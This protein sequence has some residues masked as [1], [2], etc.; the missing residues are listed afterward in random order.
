VRTKR[1]PRV[2]V[3]GS[4]VSG[5]TAAHELSRQGVDV[6][7]YEREPAP[8]GHVKTVAVEGGPRVDTGFIVY[9][10]RT[11]PRF[12]RLLAELGVET[13][14]SDMS[15]SVSCRACGVEW[16]TRGLRNVFATRRQLLNPRHWGMLRDIF[17]FY[18]DAEAALEAQEP[19]D[20]TLAHGALRAVPARR[21]YAAAEL[22]M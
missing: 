17:R 12:T 11:Y 20:E 16:A 10:E 8:G 1:Q 5:L 4:G 2:A 6:A 13:Q 14:P 21:V 19:T 18:R 7:L 22:R 3:I 15:L 9:N